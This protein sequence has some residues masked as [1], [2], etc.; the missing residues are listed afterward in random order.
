MSSAR[1]GRHAK[2][3]KSN[4]KLHDVGDTIDTI[5]SMNFK[6]TEPYRELHNSEASWTLRS[7]LETTSIKKLLKFSIFSPQTKQSGGNQ[8]LLKPTT[9]D[10]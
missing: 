4:A 5:D 7:H 10:W 3:L 6:H 2:F 1:R 9:R 8:L